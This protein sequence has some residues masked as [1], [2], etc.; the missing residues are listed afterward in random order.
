MLG[1][2]SSGKCPALI[3][4]GIFDFLKLASF[5]NVYFILRV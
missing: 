3:M 5:V 1:G 4:P 2:I